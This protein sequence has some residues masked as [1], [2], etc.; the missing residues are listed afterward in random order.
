M[1]NLNMK[2]TMKREK[3]GGNEKMV[4]AIE[5]CQTMMDTVKLEV[6]QYG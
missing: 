4:K 6:E 5:E 2:K 3:N 1:P